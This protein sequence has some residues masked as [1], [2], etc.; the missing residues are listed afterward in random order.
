M[1]RTHTWITAAPVL[2]ALLVG[3]L[4]A[5]AQESG[6]EIAWTFQT[7]GEVWSSPTVVDGVVYFGSDDSK[8]Y[9]LDAV[10][11]EK[12]WEFSAGD[13]IRSHPAIVDG[14]VYFSSDDGYLYAVDAESG[15]EVWKADIGVEFVGKLRERN[16]LRSQWDYLQSSPT[17]A[18]GVVYVGSIYLRL[19]A[20]DANSGQQLWEAKMGSPVRSSPAVASGLVVVGS[21]D[22]KVY[23]FDTATGAEK[24]AFTTGA[25]VIPSPTIVDGVVYIG[26]R[27]TFLYAL[28]LE[29][30]EEIWRFSY[31]ISWVESTAA[32]VDNVLYV[33]SS[34]ATRLY[35][36]NTE[37]GEKIWEF[38]T[39]GYAWCSPAMVDG[40]VYIGSIHLTGGL[41]YAVDAA[42]GTEIWSMDPGK[43]LVYNYSGVVSSPAVSK[44]LVYFGSLDGK[45]YAVQR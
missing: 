13:M 9:A 33:G 43:A 31:G 26:S 35:A 8:L 30:G 1:K 41:F 36:I 25:E 11:G 44:G 19:Y 20:I 14:V 10:S 15:A 45:L 18:D 16:L 17:V 6:P 42:T 3:L 23:A 2:A 32:Y 37:N 40:V 38:P 24:W 34:D 4:P 29:S 28:D 7:E 12:Q 5:G 22:G 39:Q 27:S 21:G